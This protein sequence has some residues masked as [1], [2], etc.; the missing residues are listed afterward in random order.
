MTLAQN[1]E[2]GTDESDNGPPLS[3]KRRKFLHVR[4]ESDKE[5]MSQKVIAKVIAKEATT[6]STNAPKPKPKRPAV[7]APQNDKTSTSAGVS[8]VVK[9]KVTEAKKA[10]KIKVAKDV[11]T[12]GTGTKRPRM[13]RNQ[14][15]R[16]EAEEARSR[17]VVKY[18]RELSPESQRRRE[19][20]GRRW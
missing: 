11:S 5:N 14:R 17:S 9:K 6:K 18:K 12:K 20:F 10:S 19:I 8:N 13:T 16:A 3:Q 2:H 1:D 15:L 4:P 7:L